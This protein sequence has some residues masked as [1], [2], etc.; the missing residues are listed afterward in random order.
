MAGEF[1]AVAKTGELPAGG[2]KSVE[3][4]GEPVALINN[5]GDILAIGNEC[6]HA[7]ANLS[8]GYLD[9]DSG[10]VECPLHGAC[11]NIKTGAAETPP[12]YEA[13]PVYQVKVEDD[14]ILIASSE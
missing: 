3:L 13:V 2:M 8:D 10:V 5:G 1:V 11:F 12:A 9:G 7:L 14:N 4:N 6:T